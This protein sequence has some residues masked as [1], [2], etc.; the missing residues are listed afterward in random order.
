MNIEH[1]R[2]QAKHLVKLYPDIVT[3]HGG[4]LTLAEAQ[5]VIARLNGFSSWEMMVKRESG[6][7]PLAPPTVSEIS[8]GIYLDIESETEITVAYST[9][10]GKPTRRVPGHVAIFRPTTM[11]AEAL[12]DKEEEWLSEALDAI[13]GPDGSYA[14]IPQLERQ[15]L[16]PAIQSSLE[17]CPYSI[18]GIGTIAGLLYENKD[19]EKALS[20]VE[21]VAQ[22]LIAMIPADRKIHIEYGLIANRP[23]HRLMHLYVLLLDQQGRHADADREATRMLDLH[24]GDNI[25]FRFL[26]TR[27]RRDRELRGDSTR[28]RSMAT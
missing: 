12:L 23:F 16:I 19:F 8:N 4:L 27:K 15:R 3:K 1:L 6:V 11:E 5:G 24:A 10:T 18:E 2:K 7:R 13:S 9:T 28:K 17:R 25:G 20:F 21:P 22:T 14:S 26:K